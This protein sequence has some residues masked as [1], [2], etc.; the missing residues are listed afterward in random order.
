[1]SKLTD[2]QKAILSRL[3]RGPATTDD[4]MLTIGCSKRQSATMAIKY[5]AAKIGEDR[6][7]IVRT[8]GI[9]R[10]HIG[11]YELRRMSV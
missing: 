1:M 11:T 6:L 9:G 10:G 3:E 4:I 5:L 7:A 8:S 2:Q